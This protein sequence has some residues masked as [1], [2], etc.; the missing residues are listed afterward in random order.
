MIIKPWNTCIS[1]LSGIN[2]RLEIPLVSSK[3]IWMVSAVF[4]KIDC[5]QYN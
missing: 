4:F 5:A 3:L 2:V 1:S